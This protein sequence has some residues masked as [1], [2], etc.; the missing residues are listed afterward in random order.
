[1]VVDYVGHP[2]KSLLKGHD[3]GRRKVSDPKL[4]GRGKPEQCGIDEACQYLTDAWRRMRK[5]VQRA[6]SRT[7]ACLSFELWGSTKSRSLNLE[8]A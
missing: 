2:L 8:S 1:M 5:H 6:M 7:M 4:K 3:V